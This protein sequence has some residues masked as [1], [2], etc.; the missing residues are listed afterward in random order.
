M[1]NG[2]AYPIVADSASIVT[3][4]TRI[5]NG[6]EDERFVN[7]RTQHKEILKAITLFVN[8]HREIHANPGEQWKDMEVA[9]RIDDVNT[10]QNF[11]IGNINWIKLAQDSLD[12]FNH[13]D[14]GMLES[15]VGYVK[16]ARIQVTANYLR[17]RRKC[18][19]KAKDDFLPR[20]GA[21]LAD[22]RK[23]HGD[24][25]DSHQAQNNKQRALDGSVFTSDLSSA[26]L[27]EVT[28]SNGTILP[29]PL[30][31]LLPASQ[32]SCSPGLHARNR[33]S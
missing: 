12:P 10:N 19:I 1:S 8:E 3:G 31:R 26:D 27:S 16:R 32:K 17:P 5:F 6:S 4:A 21:D 30:K 23:R 24:S 7:L 15:D 13:F 28:T 2:Q 25:D 11:L 33:A 9:E 20:S 18:T 14:R 29:A 22:K